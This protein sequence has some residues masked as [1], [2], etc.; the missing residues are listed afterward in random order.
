VSIAP[1]SPPYLGPPAHHSGHGN[2]PIVRIVIHST[3]SPCEPGGARDIARYFQRESAGGSAHYT[4][5]PEETI[6]AAWDSVVCWHAPPNPHSLG[7]EMCEYPSW[8][9]ARWLGKNHRKM[10][11]R[12]AQLTAR[13]CLAFDIPIRK[14][15]VTQ[16]RAGEKGICGHRDVSKAFGQSSHWDPGAFP[17]RKFIRMVRE[18]ADKL[19]DEGDWFDMATKKDL[20]DAIRDAKL[21]IDVAGKRKEWRLETWA[22]HQENELDDITKRLKAL[23]EKLD[24]ISADLG[25]RGAEGN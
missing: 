4:I 3:V 15:T 9:P 22:M 18:E 16:V 25:I 12:T 5:D 14:L 24:A 7:N 21:T 1:P 13:Q 23:D 2:K 10:L 20:E 19:T 17:W 11:A 8:N 6:Q